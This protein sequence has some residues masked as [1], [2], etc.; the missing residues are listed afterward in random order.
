LARFIPVIKW[1]F[2]CSTRPFAEIPQ[3]FRSGNRRWNTRFISTS[4]IIVKILAIKTWERAIFFTITSDILKWVFAVS[5]SIKTHTIIVKDFIS[6]ARIV[7]EISFIFV[8]VIMRQ[9]ATVGAGSIKIKCSFE[10]PF[11]FWFACE[12]TEIIETGFDLYK[13]K[14]TFINTLS[15]PK[16]KDIGFILARPITETPKVFFSCDKRP[17]AC[18]VTSSIIKEIF[19]F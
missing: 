10:I 13:R 2:G 5:G 14:V 7:T 4:S 11:I 9:I 15:I 16:S 1:F 18:G 6:N 17:A 19:I 3:E 12:I 8:A